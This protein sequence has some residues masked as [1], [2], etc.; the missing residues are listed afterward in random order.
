MT[1]YRNRETQRRIRLGF[2]AQYGDQ[3]ALSAVAVR[4]DDAQDAWFLDVGVT[5]HGSSLPPV[6]DGLAVR[7][8]QVG[9]ARHAV[10]LPE[11]AA[12]A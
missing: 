1:D 7:E 5:G 6:F 8:Q 10:L 3:E 2:F 4:H 12:K 9:R 11:P